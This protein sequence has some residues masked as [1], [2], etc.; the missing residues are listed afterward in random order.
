MRK[1]SQHR[2]HRHQHTTPRTPHS[3]RI[4]RYYSCLVPISGPFDL[5]S[6]SGNN[7]KAFIGRDSNNNATM[8]RTKNI[9]RNMKEQDRRT[10]WENIKRNMKEQ[11]RRT[12]WENIKRN[13]G[14]QDRKTRWENIKRN[15]K[16]QDRRTLWENIKRNMKEQDRRTGWENIKRN[17]NT[18][19]NL[20]L[21]PFFA[22]SPAPHFDHLTSTL[23]GQLH[24][25]SLSTQFY[26]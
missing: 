14:E 13:T 15:M 19:F 20:S 17:M 21:H 24:L 8:S 18:G 3:R 16:E 7:T 2:C 26:T 1:H 23:I 12:G 5:F 4:P 6:N 9:K 25:R 11:Y 22:Y 10:L